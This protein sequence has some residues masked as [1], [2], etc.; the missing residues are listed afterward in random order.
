[1]TRRLVRRLAVGL[2]LVYVLAVTWPGAT[3]FRAPEPLVFGLPLS[4]AW[5]VAWILIGW[6]T[7][8][9]LDYFENGDGGE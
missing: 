7:L 4:L 2:F 1:M 6:A 5:P 8:M 3:L 9:V